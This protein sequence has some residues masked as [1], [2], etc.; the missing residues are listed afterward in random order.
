MFPIPLLTFE[1][2]WKPPMGESLQEALDSGLGERRLDL[3]RIAARGT[4][5]CDA[6][7][8]Y[9]VTRQKRSATAFLLDLIAR[10]QDTATVPMIDV[11]AYAKWLSPG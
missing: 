4:F 10:L 11:R 1:S 6:A 5:A 2:E 8:C 7:G 9:T 3:D